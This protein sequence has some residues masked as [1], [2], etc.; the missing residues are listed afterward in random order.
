LRRLVHVALQRSREKC[1]EVG[2][3]FCHR[4]HHHLSIKITIMIIVIIIIITLNVSMT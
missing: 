3:C 2:A 1:G 4:D